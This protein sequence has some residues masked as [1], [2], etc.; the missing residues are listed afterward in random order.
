MPI[1]LI[2]MLMLDFGKAVTSSNTDNQIKS[3]K[4]V[5]KRIIAAIIIFVIPWIVE[6]FFEILSEVDLGVSYADC[7]TNAKKGDFSYYDYLLE[8]EDH[9]QEQLDQSLKDDANEEN[10]G[11]NS[12]TSNNNSSSNNN[13]SSDNNG[14]GNNNDS[15]DHESSNMA[16]GSTYKEAARAMMDMART[17]EGNTGDD[18]NA[19]GN[20]WCAIFVVYN[21][22]NTTIKNIGS[23]Y[24][25][26]SKEGKPFSDTYAGATIRNFVN[27]SNLSFYYSKYY[28]GSYVPKTGDLIYFW[29]PSR[30]G[31]K[32]W[33]KDLVAA[34]TKTD[35]VGLVDYV[36]ESGFVH[37]VEGNSGG[38]VII[39][40][41]NQDNGNIMGYGSWYK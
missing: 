4:V 15:S 13:D 38:K 26:I 1:G 37:T 16:T 24:D 30:N 20:P 29:Y 34:E 32:D 14:S 31:N 35:H 23:V 19:G 27:H 10:S 36:D 18:Y 8:E 17:Q 7:I 3:T 28:D 12:S 9:N 40:R 21:L 2:I 41:Y 6:V 33:D 5:T 39:T 25:V 22:K 11:S